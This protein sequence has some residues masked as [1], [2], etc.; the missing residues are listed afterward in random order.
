M[1]NK[2]AQKEINDIANGL[3]NLLSMAEKT[4]RDCMGQA[5]N[6][7]ADQARDFHKQVKDSN[8]VE[9]LKKHKTDFMS[10]K[11]DFGK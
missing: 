1:E 11:K 5:K 2:E 4:L 9:L 6:M 7:S 8:V 10:I 3:G